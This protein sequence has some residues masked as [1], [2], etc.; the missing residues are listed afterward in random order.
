MMMTDII[1]QVIIKVDEEI[2]W[3]NNDIIIHTTDNT[4]K[5]IADTE[6]EMLLRVLSVIPNI[7]G[8]VADIYITRDLDKEEIK[9]YEDDEEYDEDDAE[10]W[11]IA[12][13]LVIKIEDYEDEYAI[14]LN[15]A[16]VVILDKDYNE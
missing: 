4:Y 2:Y 15:G 11:E 13:K 12:S 10:E 9:E 16:D 1:G 7:S 8:R 5:I 14:Y 3:D 6:S